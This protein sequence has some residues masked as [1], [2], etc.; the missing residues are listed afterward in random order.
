MDNLLRRYENFE[1][2]LNNQDA[3]VSNNDD[4]I[5]RFELDT[6]I[7]CEL[8]QQFHVELVS[9]HILN[10]FSNI[11][12]KNKFFSYNINGISYNLKLEITVFIK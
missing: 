8:H 12:D 10:N 9:V 11:N 2:L 3:I 1:L 7:Q 4:K 5:Y 6:S